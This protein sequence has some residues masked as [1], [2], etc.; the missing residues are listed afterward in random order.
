[1]CFG[2]RAINAQYSQH[3]YTHKNLIFYCQMYFKKMFET[4]YLIDCD[5][6]AN[7]MN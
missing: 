1:M 2:K 6:K 5:C 3:L 4:P 7:S